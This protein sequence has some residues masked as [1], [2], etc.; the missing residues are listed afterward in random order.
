M[1]RKILLTECGTKPN[2]KARE[3]DKFCATLKN[4]E[5]ARTYFKWKIEDGAGDEDSHNL[6]ITLE[7]INAARVALH[8]LLFPKHHESYL[9]VVRREAEE[10]GIRTPI[11]PSALA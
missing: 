10:V 8:A 4:L 7:R 9:E 3:C 1:F 5:A 11:D 2:F 6:R